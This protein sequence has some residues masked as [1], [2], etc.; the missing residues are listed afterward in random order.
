MVNDLETHFP[1]LGG[2]GYRVTSPSD[3]KY[4]CIAWAAG[5]MW[6]WWWPDPP[7]GDEAYHWPP[8]ASTEETLAAFIAAFATLGYGPCAGEAVE[9]GW[10][11]IA[12]DADADGVPMHAAR[13]LIDGRWTSKLG[14]WQDIEHGLHDLEG[15]AYGSVV[16]IMKRPISR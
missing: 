3:R 10:A 16:Q 7:P 12:L 6:R 13:Q 15:E 5:D 2:T 9:P 14:R 1:G 8:G 11:R 4:N